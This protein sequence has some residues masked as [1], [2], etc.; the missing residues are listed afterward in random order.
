LA[1]YVVGME[2]EM[3]LRSIAGH[4]MYLRGYHNTGL[5]G[6]AGV[7]AAVARLRGAE[8]E[9]VRNA[10][11][12]AAS[13]GAGMR[14]QFGSDVMPLHSGLAAERGLAA[15][16]LAEAGIRPD[17]Q[18][19]TG[20]Y[21][22]AECYSDTPERPGSWDGPLELATAEIVLKQYPVGVPNMAPVDA[23]L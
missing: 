22:F 15:V 23:A 2:T 16:E 4:S 12:I 6:P 8:P 5:L 17:P 18:A 14:V 11:G 19:L 7:A 3:A 21:G 13:L 1:A 9:V 10:I 20:R